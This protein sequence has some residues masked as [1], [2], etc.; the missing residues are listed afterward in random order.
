MCFT[1]NKNINLVD[2]LFGLIIIKVNIIIF[3]IKKFFL[4]Y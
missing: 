1:L 4:Y 3:D 2:I